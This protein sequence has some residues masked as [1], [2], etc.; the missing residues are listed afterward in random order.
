MFNGGQIFD[1]SQ[2][3]LAYKLYPYEKGMYAILT[4]ISIQWH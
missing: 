4:Y 2:P 3:I 1:E